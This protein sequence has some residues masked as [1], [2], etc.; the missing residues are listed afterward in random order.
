MKYST[1]CQLPI[2]ESFLSWFSDVEAFGIESSTGT[3]LGVADAKDVANFGA[4]VLCV[5]E[6][7]AVPADAGVLDGPPNVVG[8]EKFNLTEIKNTLID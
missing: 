6:V 8:I 5:V 4:F 7:E 1:L 2:W 3:F